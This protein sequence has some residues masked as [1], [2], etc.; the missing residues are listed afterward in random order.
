MF[1]LKLPSIHASKNDDNKLKIDGY[2][3]TRS[4]HPTDAKT[5]VHCIC[6]K[7]TYFSH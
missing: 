3:L 1:F 4:E 2:N 5:G 6:F 7:K